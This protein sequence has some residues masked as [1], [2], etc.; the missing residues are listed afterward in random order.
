MAPFERLSAAGARFQY[1][2]GESEVTLQ[3]P[4]G[5]AIKSKDIAYS[6]KPTRLTLGIKGGETLVDE[7]LGG[8]VKC[9]DS[10]WEIE[11]VD[12]ERCVCVVLAKVKSYAN[13]E[14]CL[15]CEDKPADETVTHRVY[16]DIAVGEADVGRIVFGLYGKQVPKTVENFR[17]LC[18][19]EKGMGVSEKPLHYKGRAFHRIIPGFMCQGGD[20]TQ[21]NGTGGESIYGE[22]FEDEDFRSKHTVK[23]L[24][25]MA[26]AGPNTNGSQFFIT[27]AITGHLDGKHVVYGRVLEGYDEVV[28]KME[29]AGSGSGETS[30]VVV[31]KDCGE[32]TE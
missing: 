22:K 3:V 2:D 30:E 7:E 31:I 13:W 8:S 29:A 17:A 32:L 18:T 20:F 11:T 28:M 6:L 19:G 5:A 16:M 10:F 14:Y 21:G 25:S 27:T 12:G 1:E 24:L 26:N 9:D 23:G 4:I 15:K